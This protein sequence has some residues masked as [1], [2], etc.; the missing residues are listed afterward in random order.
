M[1]TCPTCREQFSN[2]VEACPTHGEALLPDEAFSGADRGLA[3][4][5]MVGEYS[6]EKQIGEGGFGTVYAAVHPVIGKSAAV[7]VLSR[8]FSSSPQMVSR[9][10]AEARAVNQIR[11]HNIIDIF[12]FGSL[13]DGRQY[14]VMELLEGQTFDE[15]LAARGALSVAEALP[16]LRGVARALDAAHQKGIAHRDLKPENIF[17]T[18]NDEH[19][20]VPKLLDFGIAKLMA[21]GSGGH[22]TKTGT[23]MGTP[24][25]MSPEQCFGKDVDHR[26]DIY[27]FGAMVFRVLTGKLP[28]TG[29]TTM[30][31]L[32]KH[33]NAEPP[34]PSDMTLDVSPTLDPPV[35]RMMAKNRDER[36][37]TLQAAVDELTAAA[38]M[39]VPAPVGS[40][41]RSLAT[42]RVSGVAATEVVDPGAQTYLAGTISR[43]PPKSR[44]SLLVAAGAALTLAVIAAGAFVGLRGSNAQ[45]DAPLGNR[46]PTA[47][48]SAQ[49]SHTSAV[50][51]S[52]AVHPDSVRITVVGAPPK[53]QLF[54]GDIALG[55]ASN[56]TR[57]AYGTAAVELTLKAPSYRDRVLSVVPT[58]DQEADGKLEKAANGSAQP[59][60]PTTG[61]ALPKELEKF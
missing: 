20:P 40:G 25:Y 11:H 2:D 57:L 58:K 38:G 53:A 35:L 3:P 49:P 61:A 13:P 9:F 36:P 26:T 30:E 39:P 44:R 42:E 51:P 56:G 14:Y 12:A 37:Q 48:P 7:K 34:R 52:A 6:I 15:Y 27:A 43:P 41:P 24:Y 1:A 28:F 16:I 4:G 17:L 60:T 46:Q 50:V 22:K 45:V 59:T 19:G 18:W 54:R 31:I 10:I 21:D 32:V 23:P 5:E 8:Q 47:L 55:E 29:D 33:M